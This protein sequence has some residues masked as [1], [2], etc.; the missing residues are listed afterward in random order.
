MNMDGQK[1]S[2]FLLEDV[3]KAFRDAAFYDRARPTYPLEAVQFLLEE[4]DLVSPDSMSSGMPTNHRTVLE[5]GCGTGKFTR[6]MLD[7]LQGS[8]VRVLASDLL[9][10]MRD[11]F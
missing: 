5:L 4:L 1:E 7:I 9:K 10:S 6:V 8:S 2:S 3:E 11:Q